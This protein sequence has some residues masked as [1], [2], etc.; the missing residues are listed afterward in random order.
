LI[1]KNIVNQVPILI[2]EDDQSIKQI[3]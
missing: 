1:E 2:L 3:G